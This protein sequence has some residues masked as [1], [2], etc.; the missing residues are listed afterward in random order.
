MKAGKILVPIAVLGVV[1]AATY[2]I[3]R[4]FKKKNDEKKAAEFRKANPFKPLTESQLQ[5]TGKSFTDFLERLKKGRDSQ[6]LIS[7]TQPKG[8][9]QSGGFGSPSSL[10]T[11]SSIFQPINQPLG[12]INFKPKY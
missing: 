2:V 9:A 10:N 5:Q 6:T 7:N 4:Y 8:F 1:G 3:Y 12:T 11:Q